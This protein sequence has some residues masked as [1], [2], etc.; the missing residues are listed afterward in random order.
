VAVVTPAEAWVG[1]RSLLLS[2]AEDGSALALPRLVVDGDVKGGRYVSS[3]IEL[4][5]GR[6]PAGAPVMPTLAI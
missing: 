4:Q 6:G 5:V 3:V 2:I 1:G